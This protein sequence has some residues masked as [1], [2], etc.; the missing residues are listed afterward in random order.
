MVY[1]WNIIKFIEFLSFYSRLLN[2]VFYVFVL[3]FFVFILI[4]FFIFNFREGGDWY[5]VFIF[6]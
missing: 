3:K 5:I 6:L 1:V 2:F 4:D